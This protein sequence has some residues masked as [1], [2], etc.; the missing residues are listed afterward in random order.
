LK[1]LGVPAL[2]IDSRERPGDAWRSRYKSLVLHDPVWYD[3]LPYLPFPDHWP[4]FTPKDKMGDWLDAYTTIMELNYWGSSTCG[5]ARW[6]DAA[7]AWTVMVNRGGQEMV[8]RPKH[9]VLATGMSGVPNRPSYP[10]MD[11]FK[12][13]Q[14]HSSTHPGGGVMGAPGANAARSVL[15]DLGLRGQA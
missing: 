12:G 6:D 2:I 1:R 11:R 8:I 5:H 14:H 10:G 13:V 7:Q 9:L 3:H 4:V 15:Q